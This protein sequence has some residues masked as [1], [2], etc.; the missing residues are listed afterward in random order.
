MTAPELTLLVQGLAPAVREVIT[1]A[2]AD[3]TARVAALEAHPPGRDGRDGLNGPPGLPGP[4]GRDGT[5]GTDGQDGLGFDALECQY[6]GERT[7]TLSFTAGD[8]VKAFPCVLPIPIYRGVWQRA[9]SYTRGDLTTFGGSVWHANL[10]PGEAKPGDGS[11]T[12]TLSVKRG[13]DGKD[14]T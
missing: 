3:L 10:A 4:P 6:D 12:W 14:A 2:L 1:A 7:L 11:A 5:P 9:A 13:L 8:R